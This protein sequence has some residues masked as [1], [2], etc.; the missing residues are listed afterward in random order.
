MTPLQSHLSLVIPLL[1][2]IPNDSFEQVLC[3]SS[4]LLKSFKEGNLSDLYI[5]DSKISS[6]PH[7]APFYVK[8]SKTSSILDESQPLPPQL[9]LT[10]VHSSSSNITDS[11]VFPVLPLISSPNPS[12]SDLATIGKKWIVLLDQLFSSIFRIKPR[13]QLFVLL[14]K[15]REIPTSTLKLSLFDSTKYKARSCLNGLNFIF[16]TDWKNHVDGAS[17]AENLNQLEK[18]VNVSKT[19]ALSVWHDR[20]R[21]TSNAQPLLAKILKISKPDQNSSFRCLQS[22][23]PNWMIDTMVGYHSIHLKSIDRHLETVMMDVKMLYH[24]VHQFNS[25]LEL[26]EN[27]VYLIDSSNHAEYLYLCCQQEMTVVREQ[28]DSF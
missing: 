24:K 27:C 15:F 12:S 28:C 16:G 11:P 7:N 6:S 21:K 3:S 2:G 4:P 19:T 10:T 26:F 23:I 1:L 5:S 9:H 8:L 13:D 18:T 25:A 22:T 14:A 17:F 20:A